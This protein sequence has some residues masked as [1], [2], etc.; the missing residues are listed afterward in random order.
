M[1]PQLGPASLI[2]FRR[3]MQRRWWCKNKEREVER[4]IVTQGVRWVTSSSPNGQDSTSDQLKGAAPGTSQKSP[5]VNQGLVE[6]ATQRA[7]P[8]QAESLLK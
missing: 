7:Q 2:S 3:S 8:P 4:V 1:A 5:Q 6:S